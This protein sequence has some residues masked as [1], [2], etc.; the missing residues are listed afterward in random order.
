M[1]VMKLD[2]L[3][4]NI[5]SRSIDEFVVSAAF[6][7]YAGGVSSEWVVSA[8]ASLDIQV[9]LVWYMP[10]G[11]LSAE[12]ATANIKMFESMSDK[13]VGFVRS[14]YGGV[15]SPLVV[16]VHKGHAVQ[17]AILHLPWMLEELSLL[18][19]TAAQYVLFKQL[20]GGSPGVLIAEVEGLDSVRTAHDRVSRAREAGLL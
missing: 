14:T 2:L 16:P 18:E 12:S 6:G 11:A 10:V 4:E 1:S 15:S 9:V 13:L 8:S 20:G 17:H 19:R 5:I 3:P 7:E